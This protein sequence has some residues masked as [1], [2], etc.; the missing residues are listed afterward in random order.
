[1]E[2]GGGDRDEEIRAERTQIH[3]MLVPILQISI[4]VTTTPTAQ[5]QCFMQKTNETVVLEQ[6]MVFH[7]IMV[8]PAICV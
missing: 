7:T 5:E 2:G 3:T 4:S 1:M 8:S 6:M